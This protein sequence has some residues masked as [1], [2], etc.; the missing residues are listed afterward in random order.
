MAHAQA[1]NL[2]EREE[3][4]FAQSFFSS[5]QCFSVVSYTAEAHVV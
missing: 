4:C 1:R 3:C 5:K 2:K